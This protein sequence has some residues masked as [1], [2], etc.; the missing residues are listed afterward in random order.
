MGFLLEISVLVYF[1]TMSNSSFQWATLRY[2]V[3]HDTLNIFNGHNERDGNVLLT[4]FTQMSH[5]FT[6]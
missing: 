3:L 2:A 5:F 4:Q 6:P 1:H